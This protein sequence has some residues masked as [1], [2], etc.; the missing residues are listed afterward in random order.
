MSEQPKIKI[1]LEDIE[2]AGSVTS[3]VAEGAAPTASGT[4]PRK[5]GNVSEVASAKASASE[6][7]TEKLYMKG[8]FYLGAAGLA[9][10]FLG[11]GICEPWFEDGVE[12]RG[13]ADFLMMPLVVTLMCVGFGVVESVVERSV[14]KAA[15]R[16]GLAII[17]G[18][19]L[20]FVFDFAANVIFN[21]AV[22]VAFALGVEN[23]EN[24][25]FWVARALG[26]TVF[27]LAGGIVYGLV[28][29]SVKKGQYGVL[30]G[31]IGASIGGLLF[32]PIVMMVEGA[33]LSRAFGFGLFGCATGAGIGLVES[34]LKDRWLHVSGGPLAGKQFILY[35]PVT[36]IGSSQGSDIYLF[37][38]QSILPEHALIQMRSGR[39][40]MVCSG[41]VFVAGQPKRE[42]LLAHGDVMQIGR[43]IFHYQEKQREAR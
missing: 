23:F 36:T 29:Q 2:N 19:V 43:Y 41:P 38:D 31:I 27:G 33:E 18:V 24:P 35:K 16:G 39:T 20:G 30:G 10:A 9:G 42:A 17:V 13:W 12:G 40:W 4:G 3:D 6:P 14:R 37:K 1:T 26:W 8:W 5:Y 32:D 22:G 34:A 28:G 21:I 25:G 15:Y 11:W 7:L